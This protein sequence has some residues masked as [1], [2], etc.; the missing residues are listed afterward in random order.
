MKRCP[1]CGSTYTD[2]SLRFCLQDGATL[3]RASDSPR[4]FNLTETLRDASSIDRSE[5][6]PTE[7]MN[8]GTA[9]TVQGYAAPTVPVRS[10]P[11]TRETHDEN[12]PLKSAPVKKSNP[13]LIV[14]V[15]ATVVL[16]LV[17]TGFGLV[18]LLQDKTPGSAN[19]TTGNKNAQSANNANA[20]T[21][22]STATANASNVNSNT[23]QS[24]TATRAA[25]PVQITATA[26]STL[27]PERGNTYVAS[28]VLDG[29]LLTAWAEGA[30]GP[31][32]GQWIR[33]D[34]DREV[35][36]RRIM[37]TPGYFKTTALWSQNN[38]LAA[39]TF[40]FSDG[41]SRRFTFPDRMQEQQ[42]DTGNVK[43]RWVRMV[44][45][46]TY[47][48]SVDAEDTPISQMTFDYEQ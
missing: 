26:S 9:P 27:A 18:Y 20:N 5:P 19:T 28:N 44:I 7:K 36:L 48:G 16:L 41:A 12:A 39:A 13:V 14:L 47:P 42:L 34:F 31:G 2:D 8:L 40:Y 29:S 35:K 24:N 1:A 32:T 4:N 17:L 21:S 15:T 3:E 46:D 33:C 11:S 23:A 37:I 43:T 10:H 38:R 45:E 30:S 6:P 22:N 25:A